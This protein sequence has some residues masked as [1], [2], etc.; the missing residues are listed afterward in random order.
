MFLAYVREIVLQPYD[1]T[2]NLIVLYI[3]ISFALHD[4]VLKE[5]LYEDYLHVDI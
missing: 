3:F 1:K 5:K 2:G 4:T